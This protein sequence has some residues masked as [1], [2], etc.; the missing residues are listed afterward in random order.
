[1]GLGTELTRA[2]VE[3]AKKHGF[4]ILQLSVY[5]INKRALH[6]YKKCGYKEYGKLSHDI[7]FLAG[8][9]PTEFLWSYFCILDIDQSLRFD[10]AQ[11]SAVFLR[12]AFDSYARSV[13]V[14]NA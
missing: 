2:F 8:T 14:F 11:I 9:T 10:P 4:E 5:A 3:A 12:R 6:V 13:F 7:K 1:M